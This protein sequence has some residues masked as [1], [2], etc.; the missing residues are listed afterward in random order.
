LSAADAADANH[1][2]FGNR[3]SQDGT[4]LKKAFSLTVFFVIASGIGLY[5]EYHPDL[6][7]HVLRISPWIAIPLFLMSVATLAANGLH[8]RVIAEKFNV[9]LKLKEWFGLASVTAMGNYLT[10][11][12]GGMVA[13]AAYLKSCHRF[14]Y[15]HFLATLAA[16]YMIAFAVVGVTGVVTMLTLSGTPRFSWPM[17]LFFLAILSTILLVLFLP[18]PAIG[19]RHRFLRLLQQA[20]EGLEIIR[21]DMALLCKLIALTF[22]NVAVGSC[23]F[24]L[25]FHAIGAPIP[26][27]IALLIYLL[28]ACTVLI[29]ITPG[30]LGVQEVVTALAAAIL[31]AG[32]DMGLLASLIVRAVTILAAFTLGPIFS[33]LLSKELMA[34]HGRHPVHDEG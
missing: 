34:A 10:P 12:S 27:E 33:Y 25:V 28:T 21:R 7:R 5:L 20:L 29:N 2:D 8:L 32:A 13:R 14:P 17:I 15:A 19:G 23:L 18:S 26:F 3:G 4:G 22:F 6:I 11:F 16:N 31:G 9:H 1:Q 24:F 30:N